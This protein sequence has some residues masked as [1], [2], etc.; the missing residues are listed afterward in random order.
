MWARREPWLAALGVTVLALVA[1]VLD[2]SDG[3]LRR[4]WDDHAFVTSLVCGILVLLVTVLVADRVVS[5][6]QLRDRSRAIAAQGAIVMSQAARATRAVIA[7]VDADGDRDTAADELRTYMTM[8]LI[9]AP[10]LIDAVVSRAFLEQAQSLAAELART[11]AARRD[12]KPLDEPRAR[13][14]GAVDRMRTASR[15]L[16]DILNPEERTVVTAEDPGNGPDPDAAGPGSSPDPD[17]ADPGAEASP[18]PT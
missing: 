7:A 16:L 9:S 6:R 1:T 14:D 8:L 2:F 3:S 17:A 4:W 5:A 15:P 10:L 12:G 13:L 18:S 11:M